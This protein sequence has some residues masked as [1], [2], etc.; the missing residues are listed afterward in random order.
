MGEFHVPTE[1]RIVCG[2]IDGRC[3]ATVKPNSA[4]GTETL[5]V[6]DD[7]TNKQFR[8]NDESTVSAYRNV[9]NFLSK[10]GYPVG[11]HDD[12]HAAGDASGCGANDKLSAIYEMMV[13]KED[14][15]RELAAAYG[16]AVDHETHALITKNAANRSS[17]STG[18]Q[19]KSELNEVTAGAYDH[20]RGAHKEV[21][22]VLNTKFG[23]S[24]DRDALNQ[25]F[26]D[27]YQ[28]F[29][30]DVWAFEE[31]ANVISTSNNSEESR[32]KVVAMAYY[33][34]ATALVLCGPNM[35]VITL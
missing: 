20:L 4:G 29:N 16:I 12:D 27:D 35:R 28:A 8:G 10:A 32:Q 9:V 3:G 7:L 26:G 17:F 2:C 33:N 19:I 23:T 31:S 15:I 1:H 14:Y 30:I 18:A 25:E 22:A 13:R 34:F 24:L 21:V 5:M 11:G 6:A